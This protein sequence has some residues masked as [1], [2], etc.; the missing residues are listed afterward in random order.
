M[1]TKLNKPI[2]DKMITIRADIAR[3]RAYV[4]AAEADPDPNVRSLSDWARKM[5]D[6][7]VARG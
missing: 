2:Q 1:R 3:H 6:K 7:A 5:L 4:A